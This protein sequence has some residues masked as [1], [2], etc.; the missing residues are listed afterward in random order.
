MVDHVIYRSTKELIQLHMVFLDVA[1]DSI[2]DFYFSDS[3][4]SY[5]KAR[6]VERY[7]SHLVT[8]PEVS[9]RFSAVKG[10]FFNPRDSDEGKLVLR[11]DSGI[12]HSQ[13]KMIPGIQ[14]FV[15][16]MSTIF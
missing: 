12:S 8:F 7:L 16:R 15:R 1:R 5:I 11:R 13:D 10:A 2:V 6:V 9:P 4:P 14:S 3:D